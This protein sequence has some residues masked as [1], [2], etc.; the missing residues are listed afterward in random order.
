METV[1]LV[2]GI[3]QTVLTL[4]L[5]VLMMIP[6]RSVHDLSVSSKA[7]EDINP[8]GPFKAFT[9]KSGKR[10]PIWHSEEKE[11]FLEKERDRKNS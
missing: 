3:F 1:I 9:K 4:W 11:Y 10:S 8:R 6:R 7:S 5:L 2:I